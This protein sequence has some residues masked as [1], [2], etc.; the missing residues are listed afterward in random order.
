[1]NDRDERYKRW[2]DLIGE[3]LRHPLT[4]FPCELI[5][6]E[7][8]KT[9]AAVGS[10]YNWSDRTGSAGVIA[11]PARLRRTPESIWHP[12]TMQ[13][14]LRLLQPHGRQRRAQPKRG[15]IRDSRPTVASS[16]TRT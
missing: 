7:R 3:L 9:F 8:H 13:N 16:L 5:A 2:V 4:K 14:P 10:C 11:W 1:M 6:S 12:I 15:A